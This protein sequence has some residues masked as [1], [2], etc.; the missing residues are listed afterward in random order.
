MLVVKCSPRLLRVSFVV[1]GPQ[2][3]RGFVREDVYFSPHHPR[4]RHRR[5]PVTAPPPPRVA[6]GNGKNNFGAPPPPRPGCGRGGGGGRQ[7]PAVREKRRGKGANFI[8]TAANRGVAFLSGHSP[9]SGRFARLLLAHRR[10][11]RRRRRLPRSAGRRRSR[12]LAPVSPGCPRATGRKDP[13]FGSMLEKTELQEKLRMTS[14]WLTHSDF[15]VIC[16]YRT[17][18]KTKQLPGSECLF[19]IHCTSSPNWL[20]VSTPGMLIVHRPCWRQKGCDEDALIH[21]QWIID[22]HCSLRECSP[23]RVL[24]P[25]LIVT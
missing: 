4:H 1:V 5:R 8:P 9:V 10:R 24:R 20:N 16:L 19:H 23:L 2:I 18:R 11:R 3:S 22:I 7:R 14:L 6:V 12:A 21:Y 17:C 25:C 13:I 15:K